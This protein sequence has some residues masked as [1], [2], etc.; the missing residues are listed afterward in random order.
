MADEELNPVQRVQEDAQFETDDG[1][2][3]TAIGRAFRA[4]RSDSV[5][6]FKHYLNRWTN[7]YDLYYNSDGVFEET[8]Q[9]AAQG[10][11]AYRLMVSDEPD[12]P[13]QAFYDAMH[14]VAADFFSTGD[15]RPRKY[16]RQN[17]PR[18]PALLDN[19]E[20]TLEA[21]RAFAMGEHKVGEA[22]DVEE[23][24]EGNLVLDWTD[25]QANDLWSFITQMY[26]AARQWVLDTINPLL[27]AEKEGA[28]KYFSE[29]PSG[30]RAYTLELGDRA[31]RNVLGLYQ[32]GAKA[33][34]G[35]RERMQDGG[36]AVRVSVDFD[37]L[38]R[39]AKKRKR[40]E[41]EINDAIADQW[42]A[43]LRK[44]NKRYVLHP[45]AQ[46][47]APDT[48]RA[49]GAAVGKL[50]RKDEIRG[51]QK[52]A[53]W[54]EKRKKTKL[55]QLPD[56]AWIQ[57]AFNHITA[58]PYGTLREMN[59]TA[60]ADTARQHPA[61][62]APVQIAAMTPKTFKPYEYAGFRIG[63]KSGRQI[64]TGSYKYPEY[65][66]ADQRHVRKLQKKLDKHAKEQQDGSWRGTVRSL[67]GFGVRK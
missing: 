13:S 32:E 63:S 34:T 36:P 41:D 65:T 51:A 58:L 49:A 18:W 39:A 64:V 10:G 35:T 60:A 33:P 38:K 15:S 54:R 21:L 62:A 37:K 1:A 40:L 4:L 24:E 2:L 57:Q 59:G 56:P 55:A 26:E 66:T 29:R 22:G 7:A 12:H 25:E 14:R 16:V 31:T 11:P 61:V 19:R 23:D 52:Q 42:L 45:D 8:P 53:E 30:R 43:D 5:P 27:E 46:P 67:Y 47:I 9:L 20:E 3:D 48:P 17:W 50:L 28:I 6:Y 44:H